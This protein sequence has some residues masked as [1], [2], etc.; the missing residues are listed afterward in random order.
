VIR[1]VCAAL[2]LAACANT[3]TPAADPVPAK[4][5]AAP[6]QALPPI[7]LT[8]ADDRDCALADVHLDGPDTCCAGCNMAYA[9]R[10]DWVPRLQAACAARADLTAHCLPLNCPVG[11]ERAVCRD[12]RC[13]VS[14]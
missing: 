7:E 13:T 4:P 6:V 14:F 3:A 9:A 11:A 1:A 10:A 2:V 12:H 5:A 8:C